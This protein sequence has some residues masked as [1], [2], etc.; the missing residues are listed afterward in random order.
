MNLFNIFDPGRKAFWKP[1]CRGYTCVQSEAGQYT[2]ED[3]DAICDQPNVDDYKVAVPESE[4]ISVDSYKDVP[5][6][7]WLAKLDMGES[8]RNPY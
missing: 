7:V 6:G 5:E 8:K 4:W 2:S 3:A 1:D